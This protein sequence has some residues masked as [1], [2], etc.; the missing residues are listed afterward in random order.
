[1]ANS[2]GELVVRL[3]L[4]ANEFVSGL[5][6]SEH[7]A[8]RFAQSFSNQVAIGVVKAQL[9]IEAFAQAVNLAANAIPDLIEQAGSFQDLAEKTGAS[10]EGLASFA[11]AAKIGGTSMDAVAGASVKLTKSLVGVDDE[12]KAA[13]AA[14]KALGLN[15]EAF[16]SLDPSDQI[17]AVAKALSTFEDGAGKTAVAVALFG[18]AGADMLP[19]LKELGEGVGR[20]NILTAEQIKR[21]D[22][23]ADAMA[24]SR[25]EMN[26]YAQALATEFA[27]ALIAV[28]N[29]IRDVIKEM[30]GLDK[31]GQDLKAS[32]AILD[33]AEAAA[34]AL[35]TVVEGAIGAAKAVRAISGSFEAV[36]ADVKL[37]ARNMNPLEFAKN[38]AT[39]EYAKQLEERN[40]VVQEANQRYVDLWNYDGTKMSKA[41][42][43]SFAR[44]RVELDPKNAVGRNSFDDG[45]MGAIL[46]P[47]KKLAFE[48]AVTGAGASKE[49]QLLKKQLD[50]D[51]R[52]IRDFAEDQRSAYQFANQYLRG[53]YDDGLLSLQDYF[54]ERRRISEAGVQ[55]ELE[56]VDAQIA[57]LQK[58]KPKD[59]TEAAD[60]E[61]KIQDLVRQRGQVTQRAGQVAVLSAQ[62]EERAVRQLASTYY[63]FLATVRQQQGDAVGAASL[64]IA[65]QQRD[66]QEMLTKVGFSPEEAERQAQAYGQVL[67]RQA[68]LNET[69][70]E[71]GRIVE[72]TRLQEQDAA[73]AAQLSGASELETMQRIGAVRQGALGDMEAMVRKAQELAKELGTPEAKLF[74]ERLAVGFRQAAAEADPVLQKVRDVAREMAGAISNGFEDA[75]LSG[76]KF[77]DVLKQIGKDIER[78]VFRQLVT[79]PLEDWLTKTL[80]GGGSG[81]GGF[82]GAIFGAKQAG[83]A[84]GSSATPTSFGVV[85]TAPGG[86]RF[87]FPAVEAANDGKPTPVDASGFTQGP[88]ALQ[89]NG[90]DPTIAA[91]QRLIAA[92]DTA[93]VKLGQVGGAGAA[94]GVGPGASIPP[95]VF[96]TVDTAPGG[97]RVRFP[98]LEND[99]EGNPMPLI[100]EEQARAFA[101]ATAATGSY[102]DA[103]L[104]ALNACTSFGQAAMRGGDALSL[105]PSIIQMIQAAAQA[106]SASSAAGGGG[107][108]LGS[109]FGGMGGR[110]AG[111]AGGTPPNPWAASGSGGFFGGTGWT[112]SVSGSSMAMSPM[113]A[114]GGYTGDLDPKRVAGLV[115]GKEFVF[116]A[117][118]TAAIGKQALEEIHTAARRGK[119]EH[120]LEAVLGD[121]HVVRGGRATGGSVLPGGLYPVN[122]YGM[123]MLDWRGKQY[124]MTGGERAN[125]KPLSDAGRGGDTYIVHVNATPGMSS[126]QAMNQGRDIRRGMQVQAG[127]R[128]RDS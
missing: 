50:G 15:V 18:K 120:A 36:A 123:E 19:F 33:F 64:R 48:G 111:A 39:G 94:P 110:G 2:L 55:A 10:A 101:S 53:V 21:A 90:I 98:A 45:A 46:N 61:N 84:G 95:A 124:L 27:P 13:G 12:S 109:I 93:A 91:F 16:K 73:T 122:E 76:K 54:A 37:A 118:A 9:A 127:R 66:A 79:K 96:G 38:L 119:P 49:A 87:R 22:E 97:T 121:P 86:T 113:F 35:A 105:L 14:L 71:Y 99:D 80:S 74:A 65:K 69:A 108:G 83:A 126:Q 78:I 25:A 104:S 34:V 77:G 68:A 5:T 62:E 51:L 58:S 103:T 32:G 85:D 88:G 70:A 116:S 100:V 106:S 47:K 24:K 20:V 28:Q 82:L 4:D 1:M 44:Q 41:V 40:R 23:F 72:R 26:V 52:A 8:K 7:Q 31:A 117:E 81:G 57:R 17:E 30:L 56:A 59:A 6:K 43:E 29:A 63:D 3:G 92:I 89:A 107:G 67:T 114:T 60:R 102:T 11:V 112:S 75:I 128:G 42:R 115:H 125:V